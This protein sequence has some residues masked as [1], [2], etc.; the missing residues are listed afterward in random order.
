[1]SRGSRP[2][3]SGLPQE[4]IDLIV[5]EVASQKDNYEARIAALLSFSLVSRAFHSRSRECLF[6]D[7]RLSVNQDSERRAEKLRKVLSSKKNTSLSSRIRSLEYT[8]PLPPPLYNLPPIPRVIEL[9]GL[10]I[11]WPRLWHRWQDVRKLLA[12][13]RKIFFDLLH[14]LSKEAPLE[15]FGIVGQND[16]YRWDPRLDVPLTHMLRGEFLRSLHLISVY[17]LP[18]AIM[19]TIFSSSNVQ[20]LKLADISFEFLSWQLPPSDEVLV[21]TPI[22]RITELQITDVLLQDLFYTF[23]LPNGRPAFPSVRRLVLSFPS[24]DRLDDILWLASSRHL[25]RLDSLEFRGQELDVHYFSPDNFQGFSLSNFETLRKFELTMISYS[26][27]QATSD[28]RFKKEMINLSRFFARETERSWITT[29]SLNIYTRRGLPEDVLQAHPMWATLDNALANPVFVDL[30]KRV[31]FATVTSEDLKKAGVKR[32]RLIFEPTKVTELTNG[33]TT[34]AETEIV[35]LHFKIKKIYARVNMDYGPGSRMILDT[36]LLALAEILSNNKRGVAILPEVRIA[37]GDGIQIS[38]P[39]SGYELWLTGNADYAV[40]KYDDVRDYKDR[41][42]APGGSREDAFEI[43]KG[44]MFLVQAKRQSLKQSLV[45]HIP[46]AVSQAIALLKSANSPEVRFC[47]SDGQTWIFFIL[48][49]EDGVLTYY[50]SAT[51]RLS[52]DIV[53]NSDLPLREIVQLL[54]EWLNPTA[55]EL[56]TLE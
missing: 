32:K 28:E 54:C 27:G 36:I 49:L 1:M 3:T 11:F 25:P 8:F 6:S 12:P 20:D 35:D 51:R 41:L 26:I 14:V 34:N 45:S 29:I 23:Q 38:H 5:D 15:A 17:N 52:R 18:R 30:K 42:L 31:T 22:S 2:T 48:R 10:G 7:I 33:L 44:F 9:L 40:I 24:T 47:L 4:I 55:T 56:F 53:E 50:E 13:R 39:V 16:V 19:K 21:T 43:S 46:E 37:Q